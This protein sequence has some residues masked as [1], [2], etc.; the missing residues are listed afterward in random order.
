MPPCQTCLCL[1]MSLGSQWPGGGGPGALSAPPLCAPATRLLGEGGGPVRHPCDCHTSFLCHISSWSTGVTAP[2]RTAASVWW[3]RWLS[4]FTCPPPPAAAFPAVTA[5]ERE[6]CAFA[7]SHVSLWLRACVSTAARPRRAVQRLRG[8]GWG[9]L[10]AVPARAPQSPLSSQ[11]S[12]A[13]HR[14]RPSVSSR[15]LRWLFLIV[16]GSL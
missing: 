16:L 3:G 2:A 14:R 6:S 9:A 4:P 11:R 8:A 12:A 5:A 7:L 10:G 13:L 1:R 15:L